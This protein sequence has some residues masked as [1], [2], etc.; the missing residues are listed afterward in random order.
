MTV[1]RLY[2]TVFR[3]VENG[4]AVFGIVVLLVFVI[5]LLI[6]ERYWFCTFQRRRLAGAIF[7]RWSMRADKRSY[8]A[9]AIRDCWVSRFRLCLEC[10]I[11]FIRAL[12]S[13]S[14]LLGLFGTVIGMI[15]VFEAMAVFG[16]GG[17]GSVRAVAD[18]ITVAIAPA[19]AGLVAALSA[20]YS[21]SQLKRRVA[22][23]V[24]E[25]RDALVPE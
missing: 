21:S 13:V 2:D 6:I 16:T 25:L 18:G 23:E 10:R 5:W 11:D 4:G 8:A 24:R 3:F 7:S 15:G 20:M 17:W 1:S 14:L 19:M 22:H 12:V 9:R